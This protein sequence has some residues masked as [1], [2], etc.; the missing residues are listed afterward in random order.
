MNRCFKMLLFALAAVVLCMNG[1]DDALSKDPEARGP[2][3]VP[4]KGAKAPNVSVHVINELGKL[5]GP[6]E[7]PAVRK[8][9]KEWRRSLGGEAYRVLRQAGT[10]RARSSNLLANKRKGI[11]VCAGCSLPLFSSDAKFK[12]GTGW[13]SFF[14]PVAAGNVREVSDNAHG[15]TRTEVRCSRC[16]GHLGHVFRDGPKPTGL[17]YCMNGVSLGFTNSADI[18]SLAEKL[19]K[20]EV[21]NARAEAVFAGG[22]FWC[23]E[24][25]FEELDGVSEAVSGYAGG[26][27]KDAFYGV[28]S[29]GSTKHA[30][31][32]KIVY[33]PT[34][35]T[36]EELLAVHFATHDPTTLNRQGNDVGAHYRSA[37]F[38]ANEQERKSAAAWIA[39]HQKM[40]G[41]KK[42]IVTILEPLKGFYPAEPKHQNF[43]R[44]NPNQGYVRGVALPKVNKVRKKFREKIRKNANE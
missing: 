37:I 29:S 35:I 16:E 23:V 21:K 33:D 44:N 40:L 18:K 8:S 11:Y 20:A 6:V 30:E 19:P 27:V 41:S 28:V 17:R 9:P 15:M 39:K 10:E 25:V 13:P 42:K 43:V 38:Y 3:V 1:C 24:A 32:V 31:A 22:C 14:Q 36:Y 2:K 26:G 5:K 12:S 7:V 34:K 4:A